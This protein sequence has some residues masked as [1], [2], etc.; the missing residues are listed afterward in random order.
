[1]VKMSSMKAQTMMVLPVDFD[2]RFFLQDETDDP[3]TLSCC[4]L[5]GG[6]KTRPALLSMLF[7]SRK[8]STKEWFVPHFTIFMHLS[9]ESYLGKPKSE[10]GMKR[11]SLFKTTTSAKKELKKL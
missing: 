5:A 1:M 4:W 11:L 6:R 3:T 7:L 9:R 8:I 10:K 2:Q